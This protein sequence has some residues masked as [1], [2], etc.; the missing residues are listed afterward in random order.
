MKKIILTLVVLANFVMADSFFGINTNMMSVKQ[1]VDSAT[2]KISDND[3]EIK[4]GLLVPSDYRTYMSLAFASK[5]SKTVSGTQMSYEKT[6]LGF[7]YDEFSNI[8]S[9][10]DYNLDY[11][12][13]MQLGLVRADMAYSNGVSKTDGETGFTYGLK[14]GLNL[15]L[16]NKTSI[17]LGYKFN[18][19][20][21]ED[22]LNSKNIS[23]KSENGLFLGINVIF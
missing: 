10:Y 9:D 5:G 18:T 7:N 19:I 6:T 3:I 21:L 2:A 13:G 11:Y 4:I 8:T 23:L 15:T 22:T 17:E 12:V 16:S 1:K 20:K 14:A